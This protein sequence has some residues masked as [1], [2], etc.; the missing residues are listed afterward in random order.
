MASPADL[1]AAQFAQAK[2]YATSAQS[3]LSAFTAA[4]NAAIY[5]PPAIDINL[6][7]ISA[8]AIPALPATPTLPT[9]AFVAP[10]APSACSAVAPTVDL[11]D[12]TDVVPDTVWPTAPT[13]E[14][15][16]V[17]TVPEVGVVTVPDA[18]VIDT[19]STPTY[20]TLD[21]PTFSGID[22]HEDWLENLE[23][24]P[25][26]SLMEPTPY[27]Y[28]LGPEYASDLLAAMTAKLLE[29][30]AGGT[31]LDA[32]VEAAIWDRA[33]S[34]ETKI[35]LANE[36]EVMRSSEALGFMLPSGVL[37]AQLREAQQNTYDKASSLSRDVAIKQAELEQTNLK[38]TITQGMELEGK[39]IDYSYKMEL[40][41][42]EDAKTVAENALALYNAQIEQ[43][44]ALLAGY[45]L[46]ANV[47][48]TLIDAEMSKVEVY[49]AQ[50]QGEQTKA[51]INKTMVEQYK[52]QVEASMSLVKIY[53]AQV[54]AA[55]T[56]IELEKTK[57]SAAG[58][59]IKG[60]VATVNAETAKI[61]AY[62][63]GV[64][65]ETAKL[66]AYKI[67]ADVYTAKVS[68]QGEE[69]RLRLG[70]YTAKAAVKTQEWEGYRAQVEA[71]RARMQSLASQSSSL[72]DG[73][74]AAS[75]AT[76]A[77]AGAA[78][79]LWETQIQ[80]YQAGQ[81]M[82]LL[83]YKTNQDYL[84][85][86]QKARLDAAKVGAQLYAKL[87]SSA[88]TMSNANATISGNGSTSV[89]YSY[90]NDTTAPAPNLLVA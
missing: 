31:G 40:L 10:S 73:Y 7:S 27:N 1:V 61:E 46:Y 77:A 82:A 8:P 26:L 5:A 21:I 67:K 71:E 52:A 33:R 38:D 83:T 39:L 55:Q 18:P 28:T 17:P 41:A 81:N 24:L 76:E 57:I 11:D 72:T 12:F 89:S 14:Y 84:M 53:E 36:A 22:M 66:G 54:G 29:R 51:D 87:A 86:T 68:A 4:L 65:A 13:L 75:A 30:I 19:V 6:E 42:F 80:Q 62:K 64:D 34:R 23:N 25:T 78:A 90:S 63:A 45:Q 49:K 70:E 35:G 60:Y 47:Y 48:K 58:E 20:L 32:A 9:I 69:A 37:A 85:D 79:R 74:R 59:Q 56:L 88:Y 3:Q 50:L 2:A 15:G 16:A 44:K 43:Y